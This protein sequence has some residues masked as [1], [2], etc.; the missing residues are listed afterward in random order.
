MTRD[1]KQ[2]LG[3]KQ[4][5]GFEKLK[6]HPFFKDIDWE[7]AEKKQLVA[8]YVPDVIIPDKFNCSLKR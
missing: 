4:N 6:K 1:V 7:M 5:G 2:R 8:P 3:S